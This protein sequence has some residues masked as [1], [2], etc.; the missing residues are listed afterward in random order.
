MNMPEK[1]PQKP[2]GVLARIGQRNAAAQRQA[3]R[4]RQ[5]F[6]MPLSKFWHP[7]TGF[8]VVRFDDVIKPAENQS[9]RDCIQSK[10]G[11][12]AV[13]LIEMLIEP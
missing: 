1:P 3:E 6:G 2:E 7:F 9:L 10:H 13:Q 5:L 8:D 12:E 4:F 11:K